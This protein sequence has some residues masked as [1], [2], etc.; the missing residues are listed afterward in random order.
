MT[1][2]DRSGGLPLFQQQQRMKGESVPRGRCRE[3]GSPCLGGRYRW[4]GNVCLGRFLLR[5]DPTHMVGHGP[6]GASLARRHKR[7][8]QPENSLP[9]LSRDSN[10]KR[11]CN[12]SNPQQQ[13]ES[14]TKKQYIRK[15]GCVRVRNPNKAWA[16]A[17]SAVLQHVSK[18]GH[19]L[20]MTGEEALP[21]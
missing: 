12:A 21:K 11:C 1:N 15:G 4:C 17:R 9:A 20:D 10:Q 8:N 18:A 19:P 7:H 5:A 14:M 13:G 2:T 16:D 6:Q 3:C